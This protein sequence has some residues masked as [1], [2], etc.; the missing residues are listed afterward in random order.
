MVDIHTVWPYFAILLACLALAALPA[1]R[2]ADATGGSG[3]RTDTLDGLRGFLALGVFAVH[4]I[5]H[6]DY[7]LSGAWKPSSARFYNVAAVISVALFFM[8]TGF[9]FWNKLLK[10]GG[11]PDWKALY[12]GRVFRLG[13]MYVAV[14]ATMIAIVA[15][16]TGFQWRQPPLQVIGQALAWLA[17][18]ILPPPP[19]INGYADTGTILAG[20]TWTLLFEWL[21]YFSLPLWAVFVRRGRHL[22][23]SAGAVAACL[24]VILAGTW[25][26][27]FVSGVKPRPALLLAV[28]A[29]LIAMLAT[30]MLVAS[31]LHERIGERL[32]LHQAR[33]GALA[34]LAIA[35]AFAAML[36][37]RDVGMLQ[38]L[39]FCPLLG[40]F[41][42]VLCSGNDLFGALSWPASRR[43]SA[44]SYSIYLAQGLA[45]VAVFAIPGVKAYAL[46]GTLPFWIVN[47][48]CALALCAGSLLSYRYIEEPGIRA[49]KRLTERLRARRAA[50]APL[51]ASEAA[52]V[53]GE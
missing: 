46:S 16:R 48:A 12:I 50:T 13:P 30:G 38:L 23:F 45:L 22:A 42:F 24:L 40:T 9:L 27:G 25:N 29:E 7:L 35:L 4:A 51:P 53:A 15:Y 33:W 1:F 26:G 21:F 37:A 49:G 17:L 11:R 5:V 31:L 28:L 18:G 8:L 39:V 36:G 43:L 3:R 10:A 44:M 2:G 32:R 6:Y 14:V 41:L 19:A 47:I 20:V 52:A 34:L